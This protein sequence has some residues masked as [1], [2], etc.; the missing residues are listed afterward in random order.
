MSQL[1]FRIARA[2]DGSGSFRRHAGNGERARARRVPM[3]PKFCPQHEADK[4]GGNERD[5]PGAPQPVASPLNVLKKGNQ[6]ADF[7]FWLCYHL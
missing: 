4:Q 1:L 6:L 2:G 3:L 5:A 7:G